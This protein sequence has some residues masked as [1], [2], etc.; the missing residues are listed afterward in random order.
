MKNK[1][2]ADDDDDD[3]DCTCIDCT[4]IDDET[5]KIVFALNTLSAGMVHDCCRCSRSEFQTSRPA[6]ERKWTSAMSSPRLAER[7]WRRPATSVT[8]TKESRISQDNAATQI[9]CGG[10]YYL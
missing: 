7:S 10:K 9:K 1:I 2:R 4:C 5:T 3:D 6:G 8:G